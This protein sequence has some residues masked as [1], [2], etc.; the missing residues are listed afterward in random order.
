MLK[1]NFLTWFLA[2]L[3]I[4]IILI[5]MM[6]YKWGGSRAGTLT[7]II[8]QLI[9]LIF[10]GATFGILQFAYVKAF[11]LSLDVLLII[12]G[13]MFLYQITKKAGTIQIIGKFLAE[14]SDSKAFI[15]IF[16]GWLLLAIFFCH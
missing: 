13:A 8:T 7:W 12:W 2:L 10:F 16:L 3:P 6:G 1:I 9:A 14:L 5:L 4:V 11:F 15:A